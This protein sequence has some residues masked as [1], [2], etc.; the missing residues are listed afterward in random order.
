MF[1]LNLLMRTA[2][3]R[4]RS[5]PLTPLLCTCFSVNLA[6]R[7]KGWILLTAKMAMHVKK[8]DGTV[9]P[10]NPE[11]L[12]RSL[13]R[14][15][16]DR[17]TI[18]IILK[19]VDA[20]IY[21]GI[22]TK[23]LFSFV[24]TEFKKHYAHLA[25][26]YDIK[27][28]ILRLGPEGFAFEHLVAAI[29][30][31]KDYAVKTNQYVKGRLIDHEI[32]VFATKGEQSLMVECKHHERPWEGCNIQTALYVYARF[33]DVKDTFTT[34]MLVTNTKFS[35]QVITYAAGVGIDL[36]G[37]NYPKGDS[38]EENLTRFRLYPVTMLPSLDSDLAKK[39]LARRIVLLQT[40]SSM[41]EQ[42][43]A[44]VLDIS[45]EKAQ[46]LLLHARDLHQHKKPR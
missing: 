25:A 45:K 9:Q 37:W 27:N 30:E 35:P 31:K 1:Y 17:K 16:A 26:R 13:R 14:A 41:D 21:D 4:I 19:K 10:Y 44:G 6:K 22:P 12:R 2:V 24:F 20:V 40:F 33:L 32:D 43:L 39:L 36:I 28:A 3:Y 5:Y 23:K 11:K 38:L 29:F 15:G 8:L 46:K 18:D 42:E 34:P 7:L